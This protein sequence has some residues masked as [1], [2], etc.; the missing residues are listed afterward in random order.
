[1][2]SGNQFSSLWAYSRSLETD[3][4]KQILSRGPWCWVSDHNV[5]MINLIAAK[6]GDINCK[7]FHILPAFFQIQAM[8]RR[9]GFQINLRAIRVGL[10]GS[11]GQKLGGT[12]TTLIPRMSVECPK[13]CCYL[14][15]ISQLMLCLSKSQNIYR[16]SSSNSQ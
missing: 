14:S 5:A 10:L 2:R 8:C 9:C 13:D 6:F 3:P 4:W 12:P 16:Q 15:N 1:M 11:P 7:P